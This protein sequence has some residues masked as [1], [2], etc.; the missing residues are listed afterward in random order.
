MSKK[1]FKYLLFLI[2]I[3]SN[4]FYAQFYFFGR[5]KVQYED[6]D[7]KVL[8][9]DHFDIYYYGEF[10]E[11]AK[12]GA[13]YAEEAYAELKVK[14]NN[15]VTRKIPLIFYNTHIHFQQTNT[16]PGFIPEGVGGFFEF[17][18]GRVVIPYMGSLAQFEH[19]IRHELVHVF[20]VNK[21]YNIL[22]DRRLQTSKLPPLW[23][24]EGLAEYWSTSWDT[25][26][27]M[28]LRDAVLNNI[29]FRLEDLIYLRGYLMYKEGQ[30]F[31]EW[32]AENYGE[33]RILLFLENFWRFKNFYDVIEFTL[34]EPIEY[35]SEKWYFYLKQRYFTLYKDKYPHHIDAHKLTTNGFNFSPN[36]NFNGP[37]EDLYFMANRSGY[38]S[39]Y[40]M[41]IDTALADKEEAE[42]LIE[43]EKEKA[44]EAFHLLDNSLDVH[45][46]KV[47]FVTK[48]GKSDVIH[49]YSILEEEVVETL[50]WDNIISI[51]APEFSNDGSKIVFNAIDQKGFN[52]L[53]IYVLETKELKRLTNDYY[54]DEEPTFGKNDNVIYFASD[55][56]EG[57][58][59]GFQNL[60]SYDLDSKK[61]NYVTYLDANV[62]KP[63]F[64]HDFNELYFVSDYDGTFNIWKLVNDDNG[65]P[66]GIE[67]VS[68]FATSIFD[69]TITENDKIITSGFEKFS[70]QLY[71]MD[72]NI[73]PD[74]LKTYVEFE[75]DYKSEKWLAEKI[76]LDSKVD[77]IIYKNNYTLDY[78]VSQ[79]AT[80]PI[81][82]PRGG[83]LLSL[84]DL[85]SDDKYFI[86]LYNTAEVQS[87]FLKN[88]NVAISRVNQK[89]RTNFAYGVFN[90]SGRRYD[91]RESN[92]YFWERIFGGYITLLYPFS[93]FQ[94]F[95]MTATIANSDREKDVDILPRKSLLVSNSVEF[96][97]D[98][99]IWGPTGPIDGAR[100]RLLAG[101]TSD[102]KYSNVNYYSLMADYRK[103]FRL[104]RRVTLATK[105]SIFINHGKEARRF[106]AGGSWDLRGWNKWS[107]RGEK[108]WLSSIE[109]RYPFID[110]FYIRFPFFGLGF[111]SI[112]GAL[113]FDAGGAWD[114][115]YVETLGS[116]GFGVRINVFNFIALRYDIGKKIEKNFT[117]FQPKLFYQFFFGWDF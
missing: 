41:R 45:V 110:Q 65:Q 84:S 4:S 55:R 96:I 22:K 33:E 36:Y 25:Q 70:M 111:T 71:S 39:L 13:N 115:E 95:E 109:L 15:Y 46:D 16:S 42:L 40:R 53:F 28:V 23:F 82:G 31:L 117:Q 116:V 88:I 57:E 91:I 73:I 30:V 11:M 60:F 79:F 14:F 43:G 21:V 64:S 85:L 29:F 58:C 69:F 104:G 52:D 5:N 87:E 103:Y 61:V 2:I 26:A 63:Q 38:T 3:S 44:F 37:N 77:K 12:I 75:W 27:E 67:Q 54:S 18:K 94:R 19:V 78:A 59:E 10:E 56:T 106:I 105:G 97:H 99:S 89:R 17:M 32:V 49:I 74:S 50:Q 90:F 1:L 47:I 20:M 81:Y 35:I 100:F 101:Y 62:N 92:S 107:I 7:W 93:K 98:N 6:F 86:A 102:I 68:R 80:D 24:V 51:Q 108:L 34:G 76:K 83:A 8:N 114:E 9:T 72:E 112:R 66:K 113:F 48:S